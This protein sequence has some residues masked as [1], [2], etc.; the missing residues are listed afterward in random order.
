MK[1]ELEDTGIKAQCVDFARR[2]LCSK[3]GLV[4]NE[5]DIAADIWEK[6]NF[7]THLSDGRQLPVSNILNGASQP[8]N[9]GDLIIYSQEFMTTGHVA[10]ITVVDLQVGMIGVS[11]QNY[12]N[13]YQTP[14]HVRR[15][16]L[17]K[18]AN[19]YWLLD[20]YLIG[21]KQMQETEVE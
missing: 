20:G 19:Y 9:I 1:K 16:P 8:P 18:N 13:Q 11:E 21:W 2:W 5:V 10:V 12:Y 6:I 3:M 17:I 4:F 15:I 7:Y 14:N